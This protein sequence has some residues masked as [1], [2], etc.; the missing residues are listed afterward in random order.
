[1]KPKDELRS[2]VW[3]D[4]HARSNNSATTPHAG[5]LGTNIEVPLPLVPKSW[6]SRVLAGNTQSEGHVAP[7]AL[8]RGRKIHCGEESRLL[9]GKQRATIVSSRHGAG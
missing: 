1:M 3:Q 8:F 6:S 7:T 2:V 5:P 4:V 9:A